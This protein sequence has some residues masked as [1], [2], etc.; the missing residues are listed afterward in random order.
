MLEAAAV[1][2]RDSDAAKRFREDVGAVG[3]RAWLGLLWVS[4]KWFVAWDRGRRGASLKGSWGRDC[5]GMADVV[6]SLT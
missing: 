5:G 4:C 3:R 6:V 1:G 2:R